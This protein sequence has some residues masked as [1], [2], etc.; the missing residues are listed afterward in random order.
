MALPAGTLGAAGASMTG[1]AS[2]EFTRFMAS[3]L[4]CTASEMNI[5]RVIAVGMMAEKMV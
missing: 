2:T 4:V 1:A 3:V 5:T